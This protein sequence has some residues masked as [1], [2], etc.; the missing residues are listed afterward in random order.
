MPADVSDDR[1]ASVV[2]TSPTST[3]RPRLGFLLSLGT[4]PTAL[5]RTTRPRQLAAKFEVSQSSRDKSLHSA[6]VAERRIN[7]TVEVMAP[8]S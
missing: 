1:P 6:A 8:D 3:P 5:I 4:D 2:A 7:L